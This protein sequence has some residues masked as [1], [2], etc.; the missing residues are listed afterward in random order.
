MKATDRW[1]KHA[2]AKSHRDDNTTGKCD[3]KAVDPDT[4]KVVP[5]FSAGGHFNPTDEDH[6]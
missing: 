5:F 6:P 1:H 4:D 2:L 3:P